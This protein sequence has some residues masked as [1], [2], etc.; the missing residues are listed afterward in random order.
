MRQAVSSSPLRRRL[1]RAIAALI[2]TSF[3]AVGLTALP[4]QAATTQCKV[5]YTKSD[6]GSGFTASIT[7]QN[8]GAAWTSWSLGYSYSGSQTL[9][10]GW[11]ANWS[12]SGTKVTAANAAW[13]G[14]VATNGT[15]SIGANFNY[16][17]TNTDPTVFSINGTVCGGAHTAP[18]VAITSPAAGATFT[19]PATVGLTATASAFDSATISSVAYYSGTT[20]IGSATAAPYS[21]SW[22]G[23]AAGSYSI[24]A[25]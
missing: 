3:A 9:T 24:T 12:Q 1:R 14:S 18:S 22:T 11:S 10:N 17:G 19:A 4:A 7:I 5:T 25:V 21:V 20:L 15:V 2:A 8:L 23:V 16:S 6:W 13:N